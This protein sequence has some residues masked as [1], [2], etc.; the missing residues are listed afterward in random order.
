MRVFVGGI[1]EAGRG[2]V[3]G[4]MVMAIAVIDDMDKLKN[5]GVRDSKELSPQ[6]RSRLLNVLRS[7]LTYM[8]YEVIEPETIDRYVY[9]NAL[10]KL[11]AEVAVKL[12]GRALRIVN[13]VRVYIDSPDPN[14]KRYGDLIRRSVGSVEVISM[15]KADKLIPIVSAASIIAKVTRDS[16]I[17][18]LHREY[19]DF[20]S[21]Y[22]SDPRTIGFLRN[23]VREHGD[24]PPIVR[25]SWSTI[26]RLTGG[27][28]DAFL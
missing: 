23:W 13:L 16:I 5:V 14:A 22:P 9:L 20:G 24:L 19:G 11:E 17:E 10:N 25:R 21:G 3:I 26:R 6:G 2:P 12:I 4:P 28:L 27:G 18:E 15:N 1:D 8:D 7:I